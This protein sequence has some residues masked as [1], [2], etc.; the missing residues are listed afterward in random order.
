MELLKSLAELDQDLAARV[1]EA[2]RAADQKIKSAEEESQRLLAEAETQVKQ[3]EEDWQSRLAKERDEID[4]KSQ[5][6]ADEEKERLRRQALPNIDEA[7][8]FILKK[9]LP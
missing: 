5:A 3:M 7:V 1:E 9:V 6:Q 2:H 4:A 8:A